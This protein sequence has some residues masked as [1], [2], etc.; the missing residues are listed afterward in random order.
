MGSLA[1][2][3]FCEAFSGGCGG[4][5][6]SVVLFPLDAL[7][8]KAQAGGKGVGTIELIRKVWKEEGLMVRPLACLLSPDLPTKRGAS[9]GSALPL[10]SC[11]LKRR[12]ACPMEGP[13]HLT[14]QIPR[15]TAKMHEGSPR[16][17][18]EGGAH[19][20][21]VR[22]PV[23]GGGWQGFMNGFQWRGMQSFCEKF[24]MCAPPRPRGGAETR[25]LPG[26]IFS[27]GRFGAP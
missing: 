17:R 23:G 25:L 1:F 16:N 15:N 24:G 8:T 14:S 7:K 22:R 20:G 11:I 2:E 9:F 12:S 21:L 18:A 27:C 4:F 3:S 10:S 13:A 5:F 19:A 26:R 6:S